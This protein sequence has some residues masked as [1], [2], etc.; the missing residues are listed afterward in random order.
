MKLSPA[1]SA[2]L[3]FGIDVVLVAV[4]VLIGRASHREDQAGWI[5]TLWP[6]AAGLAL[7]WVVARAWRSPRA[8][9]WTGITVWALTVGVGMLLRAASGQG[10]QLAFIIVTAIV[11]AAFLLGWRALSRIFRRRMSR[12]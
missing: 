11:L 8:L 9:V 2:Y 7:G 4:F 12:A 10:V 3:S 1:A 6:F 5:N